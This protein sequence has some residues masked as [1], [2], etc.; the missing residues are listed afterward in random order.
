MPGATGS[1]HHLPAEFPKPLATKAT[2]DF[3]KVPL[4]EVRDLAEG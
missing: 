4:I 3:L 2:G 1:S